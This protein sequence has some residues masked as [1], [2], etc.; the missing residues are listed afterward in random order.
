MSK[1][2]EYKY[3][4]KNIWETASE[5]DIKDIFATAEDYK[6][7]LD[8]ARTERE[9]VTWIQDH[10][11][12]KGFVDLNTKDSLKAGDKVYYKFENKNITLAVIGSDSIKDGV[13][14]IGAHLDAP[15]LDL[16]VR[17][18]IEEHGVAMLKTHYYGGI[19]KYQWLNIPLALHGVVFKQDGTK[20]TINIGDKDDDPVFVISDLL[21]HLSRKVQG[22]KKLLEGIEGENLNLFV[23]TMPV[24]DKKI[25]NKIKGK[26]IFLMTN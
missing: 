7:F 5:Q 25:N 15:R 4:N 20:V 26:F 23:G 14:I 24:A 10:I 6:K 19:K 12:S 13:N 22:D 2:S 16:K 11:E 1:E 3:T 8:S 21:P 9:S 18:L 17:P